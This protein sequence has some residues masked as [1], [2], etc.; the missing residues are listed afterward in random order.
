MKFK[1]QPILLSCLSLVLTAGLAAAQ[2][3]QTQAGTLLGK[4]AAATK[5]QQLIRESKIKSMAVW[6]YFGTPSGVSDKGIEISKVV[7][8]KFGNAVVES[9]LG[10]AG[11]QNVTEQHYDPNGR[12]LQT[13]NG[14][15]GTQS[16]IDY[17]YNAA[18]KVQEAI[19]HTA[20]GKANLDLKYE[21]D[22]QGHVSRAV[23]AMAG[24]GIM[25][26][27]MEYGPDGKAK[28]LKMVGHFVNGTTSQT[29]VTYE[30][31]GGKYD[32]TILDAKGATVAHAVSSLDSAG[33]VLDLVQMDGK[34]AVVSKMHSSY[35]SQGNL[36]HQTM[37]GRDGKTVL[38]T[39]NTYD[40][41]GHVIEA[42]NTALRA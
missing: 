11:S 37:S 40:G 4:G 13:L 19:G 42:V 9:K 15:P 41:Q 38:D 28:T 6:Q 17:Q 32:Q 14:A 7:Y 12:L 5:A 31:G 8:D 23:T 29:L 18:G 25:E 26:D 2:D 39:A 21:Y 1:C 33:H 22:G 3:A 27:S 35:D 30:A 36:I 24:R 34:G 10:Q 16:K 20:N